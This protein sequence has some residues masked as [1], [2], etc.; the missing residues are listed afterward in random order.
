MKFLFSHTFT[1]GYTFTRP[2]VDICNKTFTFF[3][4]LM[5]TIIKEDD[6]LRDN[7]TDKLERIQLRSKRMQSQK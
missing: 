3:D 1:I 2:N 6:N 7:H 5:N 4:Y